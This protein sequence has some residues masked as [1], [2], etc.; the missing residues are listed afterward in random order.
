MELASIYEKISIVGYA[1]AIVFLL[2]AIFLFFY[3]NI[4]KVFGL[5]S[6]I[7]AKKAIEGMRNGTIK[8]EVEEDDDDT[9]QNYNMRKNNKAPTTA[10]LGNVQLAQAGV[11]P[12]VAASQPGNETVDLAS[13]NQPGNETVD[14]ASMNQQ[15]GETVDLASMNT[16]AGETVDLASMNTQAG[17]TVDLASMN[18]QAGETVDLASY[19]PQAGETVDLASMNQQAGETVD[20][21]SMNQQA[22]ETV[23][24]AQ[25]NQN[26]A[27]QGF[28]VEE[29]ISFTH[30][31][32]RIV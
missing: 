10:S 4:P 3:L 24:L 17:E 11:Q 14:L 19:Q 22:G 8:R 26:L 6:G 27:S 28:V 25:Y 30:T 20:L 1:L 13:M 29:E 18:Q 2:V 21:A 31:D 23:D 12:K 9:Y 16:Q 7:T 15:A 5:L 32:E